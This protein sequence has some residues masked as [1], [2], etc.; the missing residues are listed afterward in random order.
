MYFLIGIWGGPRKEYAAIKFF[1]YTLLGSVL[2]LLSV[3]YMYYFARPTGGGTFLLADG[4]EAKHT[5]NMMYLAYNSSFEWVSFIT[6]K[7]L[8]VLLF[9]G[10]AIKIPMFP[11]HTWLPDAHVQAPTPVSVILAGVLLKM[12]TYGIFR[13]N[14]MI[15]PEATQWAGTAMA[16]FG[17]INIVYGALV[18]MAQRDFKSMVAYSSISHMGFV[19]LGMS[20]FTIE[21]MDGA[22]FQMFNHG[23]ITSMMFL[24]VG[25]IYN[26]AHHRDMENFGGL[27][28]LMPIYTAFAGFAF[29]AALG[30]PGLSGFISEVLVFIG[31]FQAHRVITFVSMSG[32]VLGA[33]YILWMIHRVF[34]GPVKHEEYAQFSDLNWRELT[35]LVPL[36]IIVAVLGVYP[37]PALHS[38]AASMGALRHLII[39]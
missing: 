17:M 34:L 14:F 36:M 28:R 3:I 25:V 19:L 37:L 22:M 23:T 13:I 29:M 1:L 8:W 15:F 18:A 30:L 20:S 9:I 31:S 16:V 38:M 7:L 21:G 2:M 33:A 26:R 10:F 32:V 5:F 27:A 4:T 12:G 39:G 11:F 24:L 6:A 35:T